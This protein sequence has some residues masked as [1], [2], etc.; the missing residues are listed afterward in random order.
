[1]YRDIAEIVLNLPT[2]QEIADTQ[3]AKDALASFV[4]GHKKYFVTENKTS[5]D[6]PESDSVAFETYGK[7][8]DNGEVAILPHKLKQI[9]ETELGFASAEKLIAEWADEGELRR[10]DN[11]NTYKTSINTQPQ[12]TYRFKAGVFINQNSPSDEENA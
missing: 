11:R 5:T 3:R 4:A 9:L 2:T 1:M 7:I 10:Q 8:F 12:W 6:F